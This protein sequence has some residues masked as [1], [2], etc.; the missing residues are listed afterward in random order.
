M[1]T[2]VLSEREFSISG[3]A[4]AVFLIALAVEW[5]TALN[6]WRIRYLSLFLIETRHPRLPSRIEIAFALAFTVAFIALFF[7]F[8]ATVYAMTFT[9]SS[10][11]TE[12]NATFAVVMADFDNDGDLD[13]IAGNT[14]PGISLHDPYRNSGTGAF[15]HLTSFAE[16]NAFLTFKGGDLNNDGKVDLLQ[17]F[18][19]NGTHGLTAS[20]NDGTMS[21]T[22]RN[23]PSLQNNT[24][25]ALGDVN[26]DGKLDVIDIDSAARSANAVYLGS[27]TGGFTTV[28]SSLPAA[29]NLALADFNS[30]GFLDLLLVV[31]GGPNNV[32]MY[33][34][35]GT[36][37]FVPFGSSF[38]AGSANGVS[39]GDI[40]SDGDID[41]I[42]CD[43]EFSNC[44]S[45]KNDGAGNFTLSDTMALNVLTPTSVRTTLGD[46]DNDGDLDLVIGIRLAANG[47]SQIW[48]NDG[49]GNFSLSGSAFGTGDYTQA[50]AL[51]DID[52]DGDLDY[53]A[54]NN[55]QAN[56]HYKSDQ[57]VTLPN[58]APT[59]P[60]TLTATI[61]TQYP[62][63]P[64]TVADDSGT[65]TIS[66]NNTDY[67]RVSDD[68]YAATSSMAT[69]GK[70]HY[71]KATNFGFT[72]PAN[73]TILGIKVEAEKRR[74]TTAFID[75]AARIVKGGVIGTTDRSNA[76][77]WPATDAY[78]SYGSGTDL[79][80]TTWTPSDINNSNFGFAI[81]GQN[82]GTP[83]APAA[84]V[85]HIRITVY[86][87]A[88]DVRLR[89]GS[90]SDTQTATRMLQY[91]LRVGT[92]SLGNNIVSG[93]T[94]S[95]NYVT[96][97]M[98]NGQ[99]RTMLL[100]N[101]LCGL[102]YY[103]NVATVD[104]G[105][106]TTW[107]TEKNFTVSSDCSS[108]TEGTTA[109]VATGGGWSW[110]VLRQEEKKPEVVKDGFLTVSAFLDSNGN[111]RK[112]VKETL[113][114][115][116]LTVRVKGTGA[117]GESVEQGG[118]IG[119]D[120][121]VKM[122]LLASDPM[123]YEVRVDTGS[124]VLEGFM[125]G[126]KTL[127][128]VVVSAGKTTEVAF[129][130]KRK[131]LLKYQPCLTIGE[132]G[133]GG[134]GNDVFAL[135]GRLTDAYGK[136]V[137]EGVAMEGHLVKRGEFFTLL[138]RTQCIGM[139]QDAQM[140]A[141]RN[142]LR[143]VGPTEEGRT[144][145]ALLGAELPVGRET[146]E[147]VMGDLKSPI[148]R[149]EA[150]TVM[151]KALGMKDGE[152]GSG[153]T[154]PGDLQAKDPLA[155]T[156]RGLETLGVLPGSFSER[157]SPEAGMTPGEALIMVLRAAM[158]MGK[159]GLVPPT[160][161]G[162]VSDGAT[163]LASD[164]AEPTFLALL[165]PIDTPVCLKQTMERGGAMRFRD[166]APGDSLYPDV[167]ML[168]TYGVANSE[169]KTLW[170]MAGTRDTTEYG[171]EK[172]EGVFGGGEPASVMETLRA[173][174]LLTCRPPETAMEVTKTLLTGKREMVAGSAEQWVTR[175]RVSNLERGPGFP[176]RV[177]YRSQ[178]HERAYDLSLFTYA[179]GLLRK[180]ARDTL[181]PL[182]V[183]EG[184]QLLAS[185]LLGMAVKEGVESPVEAEGKAGVIAEALQAEFLKRRSVTWREEGL[186]RSA[187]FTREMLIEFLATVLTGRTE[188]GAETETDLPAGELW[189]ERIR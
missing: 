10:S 118:V 33:I 63:N 137:S 111:R 158:S 102:T 171:V 101:L 69:N 179:Q 68:N 170:L 176:S 26:N 45:Y 184:S 106:K 1:A 115:A 76:S 28:A 38:T 73:A 59:A 2:V 144:V 142:V 138:Q 13:Y 105:H 14:D 100:K 35:S 71:L 178:D 89:W 121:M 95:P 188:R 66:W 83:G 41:I 103:W 37:A 149:R 18:N 4:F 61:S 180:E 62:K 24:D 34:G 130:F 12:A 182:T 185:A 57:A 46:L 161:D 30:D 8:I 56:R 91:Q 165:P 27:G 16:S 3:L 140:L 153:K 122:K 136:K 145:Y 88:V 139:S 169:G 5:N 96:R 7:Q 120:G 147:G 167:R 189:W 132:A 80:G 87:S 72:V 23:I 36:G 150:M 164:V 17:A 54:G 146:T 134:N 131:I 78:V 42:W 155:G 107:G 116:G 143:D 15:T 175:D 126:T 86:Y 21:F 60:A 81:A 58:T 177:L 64:A 82:T 104:T 127:S 114:F 168:L 77:S 55:G 85:D 84:Y 172:G 79:W 152:T 166:L 157:V 22:N 113:G 32:K 163:S 181:S 50:V 160:Y 151:A 11:T 19:A 25:I 108:I 186:S 74:T 117:G 49:T 67:A 159:I 110:N 20:L 53:I 29:S 112:D 183:E 98:P 43:N 154:L 90:G 128:G 47:Q 31:P 52:G 44:F 65:G 70:T 141:A 124:S 156:W 119:A 123:G 99:S 6:H 148:T 92:G 39:T 93:K 75:I 125:P 174:L 94:A 40:D 97:Q 187:L 129:G 9:L 133:E 135:W 109:T 51:G 162:E 173:L 48:L